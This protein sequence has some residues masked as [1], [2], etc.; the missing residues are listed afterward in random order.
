MNR[1]NEH[2]QKYL[3]I[4]TIAHLSG[5]SRTGASESLLTL[6]IFNNRV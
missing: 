5:L 4:K 2:I 1:T 3:I 6:N